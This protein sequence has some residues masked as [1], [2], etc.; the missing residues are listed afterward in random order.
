MGASGTQCSAGVPVASGGGGV[1]GG[2]TTA[3]N[4]SAPTTAV[5]TGGNTVEAGSAPAAPTHRRS[6]S[7]NRRSNKPIMEKRRRARINN[8]LNELK[9]LILDATKKDPA[10]H[11]KLEK[12]DI[13]EMTVRHLETLRRQRA[14]LSAAADPTI[15]NKYKAGFSECAA[16]VSR[17]LMRH[18]DA[19]ADGATAADQHFK[20]RLLSHLTHCLNGVSSTDD[21]VA[22]NGANRASPDTDEPMDDSPPR[23][24]LPPLAPKQS[25]PPPG[26]AAP[27]ATSALAFAAA[28]LQLVPR[29]LPNGDIALVL[30]SQHTSSPLRT[31][32]Q[33]P[34]STTPSSMSSNSSQPASPGSPPPLVVAFPSRTASTA[35]CSSSAS[36]SSVSPVAFDRPTAFAL[37]VPRPSP[38]RIRAIK[39]VAVVAGSPVSCTAPEVAVEGTLLGCTRPLSPPLQKPLSL[40]MRREGECREEEGPWRPW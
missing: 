10:R 3:S 13:L 17:F 4:G 11:S 9:A 34:Q 22:P 31:Q 20:R 5:T 7:D 18:A 16:E 35:S 14:A 28:G 2:G 8:C 23:H 21:T 19:S 32:Q 30:P 27:Q 25:P 24:T 29:R 15:L 12:A 38:A 6:A 39:P 26:G 36:S 1:I 37:T 40:V 33:P